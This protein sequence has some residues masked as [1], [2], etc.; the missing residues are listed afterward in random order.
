MDFIKAKIK[1]VTLEDEKLTHEQPREDSQMRIQL[2]EQHRR[3]IDE[4][5][6]RKEVVIFQKI[7]YKIQALSQLEAD[8][9]DV[10]QIFKVSS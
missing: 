7:C 6:D 1:S 4:L 3:H 2:Q 8:I 9:N 10:N 5:R